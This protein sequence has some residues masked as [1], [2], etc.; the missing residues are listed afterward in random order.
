MVTGMRAI[1]VDLKSFKIVQEELLNDKNVYIAKDRQT[2]VDMYNRYSIP[3]LQKTLFTEY[4]NIEN[5]PNYIGQRD[6][7]NLD[8]AAGKL[9]LEYDRTRNEYA[10]YNRDSHQLLA[11][12]SQFK[13]TNWCIITPDGYFDGSLE[14]R[15]YLYMKT[16]SGKLVP[17]DNTTFQKLHKQ[18]NL[19]D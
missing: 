5:D 6:R 1:S 3:F 18:I 9:Y 16:L 15:K 8:S 11:K 10:F 12:L 4:E 2:I 19:K 17:I 14:A 13:D 7:F